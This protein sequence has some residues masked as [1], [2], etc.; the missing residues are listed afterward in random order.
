MH[1]HPHPLRP[2][3]DEA[4]LSS[5]IQA[6]AMAQQPPPLLIGERLTAPGSRQ[7]KRLLM[8]EDFDAILEM[9]REQ[10][11][12][13]AHALDVSVALTERPDEAYL[14]TKVVKKLAMGIEAPLVIDS[15]EPEVMEA[16]LKLAPGRCLLNSTHL[17]AGRPKMERV[18][19]IARQH[20]AAVL[21]LTIDES[22]M[23]KST[24]RKVEVAQRIYDIAVNEFGFRPEDL[25][26]DV[27]TFPLSTGDAEFN[28]SAVET[29]D[30][31]REIKNQLPGVFTSLGVSNVSFG[32]TPQARNTLNSMMLHFCVQAGLDMAIV[33]A[34]KVKPYAEIPEE[35]RALM[36]DLIFN[37]RPDALQKVIEY[38]AEH[39]TTEEE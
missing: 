4:R 13:G 22:G 33:H 6:I 25:V 5:S 27:L 2:G 36:E 30:A 39:T 14:M 34:S 8:N 17:E 29:I 37:K 7:F 32:L 15:T 16:A 18:F 9:A 23:G 35:E 1:N 10:I 26:F 3:E 20:N 21:C 19:K 28:N 31:I 12:G 38:Y 11:G 24:Q